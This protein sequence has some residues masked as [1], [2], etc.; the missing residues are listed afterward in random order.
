M[1]DYD[2]SIVI[3]TK[4]RQLHLVNCVQSIGEQATPPLQVIIVNDG[5]LNPHNRERIESAL[6]ADTELILTDDSDASGLS[7]ARNT[8]IEI[9]TGEIVLFLDDDTILEPN[10]VR[11]LRDSYRT[12]DTDELAG[13][14]GIDG[15]R[16]STASRIFHVVFYLRAR[17]WVI[18]PAGIQVSD[19]R[20]TQPV[21]AEWLPGY[22]ASFKRDVIAEEPFASW[23]GGRESFEDVEYAWRIKSQGY[24]FIADPTLEV[25]HLR[26]ESNEGAFTEWMKGGRNRVRIF[27]RHGSLFL[28]PLLLWSGFGEFLEQLLTGAIHGDAIAQVAKG[29]GYLMGFI[30][31]LLR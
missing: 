17:G 3:A 11:Q 5:K 18:N 20:I 26:A 4:D 15:S 23:E 10:F 29:T 27:R 9:A 8:G 7:D 12:H 13:I 2:V 24:H 14:G 22:A 31:E 25:T 1:A 6:P 21:E 16:K 30:S 28:L 19:H